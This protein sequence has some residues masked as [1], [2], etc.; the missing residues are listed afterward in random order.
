MWKFIWQSESEVHSIIILLKFKI[1]PHFVGSEGKGKEGKGKESNGEE[2]E[3]RKNKGR[4][5]KLASFWIFYISEIMFWKFHIGFNQE[6]MYMTVV[7]HEHRKPFSMHALGQV[8]EE[9]SQVWG[10][11]SELLFPPL[12]FPSQCVCSSCA[13]VLSSDS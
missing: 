5:G 12:L 7:T 13:V 10:G 9:K 8:E 3:R 11:P 2:N 6:N 1:K 4:K